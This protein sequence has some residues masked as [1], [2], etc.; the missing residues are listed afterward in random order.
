MNSNQNKYLWFPYI[1][2][3]QHTIGTQK[4]VCFVL[5]EKIMYIKVIVVLK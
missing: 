1:F 2:C 4:Y 5:T 3:N